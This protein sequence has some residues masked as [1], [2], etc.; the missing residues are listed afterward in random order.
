MKLYNISYLCDYFS[1]SVSEWENGKR[2]KLLDG[3]LSKDRFSIHT[4]DEDSPFVHINMYY[5]CHI[6]SI[7]IVMRDIY[8]DRVVPLQLHIKTSEGWKC[9]CSFE[10]TCTISIREKISDI[11]ILK[12]G[13][14]CIVL[15]AVNIYTDYNSFCSWYEIRNHNNL[16][17]LVYVN[18]RFYGLGGRLSVIAT[19]LGFVGNQNHIKDI[20]LDVFSA[21]VIWFPKVINLNKNERHYQILKQGLAKHYVD[22]IFDNGRYISNVDISSY[23]AKEQLADQLRKSVVISR[24]YLDFYINKDES[25]IEACRRLYSRIIPHE[26][27]IQRLIELENK[28]NLNGCYENAMA[29]HIRHGNGEKYYSPK[30]KVWGVK[31]P[32]PKKIIDAINKALDKDNAITD[33][34]VSSDCRAVHDFLKKSF[35]SKRIHYISEYV[36]PTGFG[37]N[38]NN[39]TF[40]QTLERKLFPVELED[41]IVFSE[42]LALSKCKAL[43]G[44]HSYFFEAVKYFSC[45][46][47]KKIYYLDNRDRYVKVDEKFRVLAEVAEDCMVDVKEKLRKYGI[48]IDGLFYHI[49]EDVLSLSYFD[50]TVFVGTKEEIIDNID[51]IKNNLIKLRLY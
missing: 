9:V 33:L 50:D 31:P 17:S 4:L 7:Q 10:E 28:F 30:Q 40:D 34:I 37:C 46:D 12:V 32:S 38:H 21:K 2:G 36:Q 44:G 6:E 43:C 16:D 49:D 27:V 26:K 14:G 42:I 29:V 47:V 3:S 23:T 45:C 13:Q 51:I 25:K 8:L 41:E 24:D 15:S 22:Y 39:I 1:S 20:A 35:P 11:R 19:A 18:S 5:L 48:L